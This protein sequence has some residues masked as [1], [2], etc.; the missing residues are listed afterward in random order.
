MITGHDTTWKGGRNAAQ[1]YL[2]ERYT[3]PQVRQELCQ[4][5][6]SKQ[7]N[8]MSI[9]EKSTICVQHRLFKLQGDSL[10]ASEQTSILPSSGFGPQG[11]RTKVV[12]AKEDRMLYIDQILRD[13]K[14]Q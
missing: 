12:K 4:G 7:D 14:E 11:Q 13:A 9:I 2:N 6:N 3:L 8:A 10:A 1:N 5:L